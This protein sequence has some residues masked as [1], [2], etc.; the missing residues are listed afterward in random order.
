ML[1]GSRAPVAR[2]TVVPD[3]SQLWFCCSVWLQS[4]RRKVCVCLSHY[5]SADDQ[6]AW[7]RS[8]RSSCGQVSWAH[9]HC[10][11]VHVME[12]WRSQAEPAVHA[13]WLTAGAPVTARPTAAPAAVPPTEPSPAGASVAPIVSCVCDAA[14]T[15]PTQCPSCTRLNECVRC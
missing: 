8:A 15:T 3:C 9:K 2:W 1:V 6:I 7:G 14:P 10:G 4:L 5:I 13:C 11:A 12:W